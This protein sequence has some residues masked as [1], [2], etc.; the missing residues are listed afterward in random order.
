[1]AHMIRLSDETYNILLDIAMEEGR[2]IPKQIEYFVKRL[3]KARMNVLNINKEYEYL[4]S[5]EAYKKATKE[6]DEEEIISV[7]EYKRM[8]KLFE[9]LGI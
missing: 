8:G 9:K 7:G 1:M 4:V 5:E 2:T 3:A 6:A